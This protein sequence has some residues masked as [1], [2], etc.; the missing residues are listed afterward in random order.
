MDAYA[1]YAYQDKC[2]CMRACI[3]KLINFCKH[4]H[5]CIH[6]GT[7]SDMCVPMAIEGPLQTDAIIGFFLKSLDLMIAGIPR[8]KFRA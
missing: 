2:E 1:T 6:A 4:T 7:Q 3:C 8:S 5:A